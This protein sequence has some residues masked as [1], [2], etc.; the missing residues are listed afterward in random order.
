MDCGVCLSGYDG[1]SATPYLEQ[2]RTARK[3]NKCCE[4]KRS[5]L[6]G[7]RYQ[8]VSGRWDGD[9]LSYRTCEDCYHIRMAF[10]CDGTWVFETLW[11][12]LRESFGSITTACFEKIET[13]SAKEYLR[14]C[15]IAWKFDK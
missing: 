10:A 4:C 8:F 5:I 6:P 7:Q 12:D 3:Q 14:E 1:D 13:V 9:W 2:W 15:W 11:E